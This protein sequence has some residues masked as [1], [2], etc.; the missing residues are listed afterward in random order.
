MLMKLK[1][2][3]WQKS[4]EIILFLIYKISNYEK[5]IDYWLKIIKEY[6]SSHLIIKDLYYISIF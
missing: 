2:S 1:T 4:K 6:Y 3:Y 5:P